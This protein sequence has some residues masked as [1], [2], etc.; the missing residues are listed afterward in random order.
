MFDYYFAIIFFAVFIMV[1]MLMMIHD[2][3]LLDDKIK[4]RFRAM[5]VIVIVAAVSE[6]LGVQ[7]NNAPVWTRPVH[8]GIKVIE[9]SFAPAISF[10]CAGMVGK[11]YRRDLIKAFLVVHAAMELISGFTGFIFYVDDKNVYHHGPYYWIYLVAIIAG[12]ALFMFVVL[13]ES[14]HQYGIHK[15]LMMLLPFFTVCGLA[16]EYLG[17]RIRVIWLC[18]AIDVLIIYILYIELTQNTDALTH[19]MNRR[20]YENRI[21]GLEDPATIFYFDVD[22]FKHI[23]DTYGHRFGDVSLAT[24]GRIMY[25]IFSKVGYCYR[26]GGDEFAAI[27]FIPVKEAEGYCEK[28]YHTMEI[29]RTREPKL[30]YVSIGYAFYDPKK[31]SIADVI[32][33]ADAMMYERKRKE[34]ELRA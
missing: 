2:N 18:S 25:A 32:N 23:N 10:V 34:K 1:I 19:L 31:D 12:I 13:N 5:A 17:Q 26:I 3:E 28:M 20:Y 7:L 30:P 22:D 29:Q 4:F 24:V 21:A 11:V 14:R 8:I 15:A 16:F 6:W 9:L 33:E 27:T